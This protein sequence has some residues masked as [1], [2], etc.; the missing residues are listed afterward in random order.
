MV[1][2][3]VGH[4]LVYFVCLG[5]V[6]CLGIGSLFSSIY[7]KLRLIC[8]LLGPVLAKSTISVRGENHEVRFLKIKKGLQNQRD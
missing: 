7:A 8:H 3:K 6:H 2:L 5:M 1:D 4:F